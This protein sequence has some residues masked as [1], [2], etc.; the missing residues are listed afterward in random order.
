MHASTHKTLSTG[1]C[2]SILPW[3][4]SVFHTAAR[5]E[6]SSQ[7]ANEIILPSFD[8]CPLPIEK[9]LNLLNTL[10]EMASAYLSSFISLSLIYFPVTLKIF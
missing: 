5:W 6:G 4:Q 9:N 1:L 2:A 3:V 10:H 7:T 8:G